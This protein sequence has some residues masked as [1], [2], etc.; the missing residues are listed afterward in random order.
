MGGLGRDPRQWQRPE[1]FLPER[2]DRES[3]L[4]LTPSKKERHQYAWCPFMAGNRYCIGQLVASKR[5]LADVIPH[6]IGNFDF[7]FLD[8]KYYEANYFPH[9][10]VM[11]PNS[12]PIEVQIKKR[13]E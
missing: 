11:A 9:C 10:S 13:Y 12:Y 8:K 4:F 3:E 1:E 6:L 2:F 5:L 7:V